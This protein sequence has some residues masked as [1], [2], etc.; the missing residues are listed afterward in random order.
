VPLVVLFSGS[1]FLTEI[2]LRNPETFERLV[3][4][5]RMARPKSVEQ[6]FNEAQAALEGVRGYPEQ[7][8]GL[9][10]FQSWEMLR[11][12]ACD[13][14]DLYDLPAVT[15]QLSNLADAM[16]RACLKLAAAQAGGKIDGL[17]VLG[18]GKLGGREL[19]YSSD[20]D[21]IFLSTAD[22]ELAQQV[23]MKLIDALARAT[24]EG[25]LYRVDMRLRPW[26]S[27]GPLVSTPAG[28]IQYLKT[29][30]LPWEKQALLKARV[31]A[32]DARLGRGFLEQAQPY[33]FGVSFEELRA[34]GFS[35]K[36]RTEAQLRLNG[37][38][39]GEVK[40]GEGSIRDVE[41]T[42]QFLQLAYG[43]AR[44]EI[45]SANTL[46]AL[47]RLAAAEMIS[48]D[49]MRILTEGDVFLR[50]GEHYLQMMDCRQT[51]SLP[52]DAPALAGLARRLGF[53]GR[54]PGEQFVER[55][56]QHGAAIR[57]VFLHYVGGFEMTILPDAN[58]TFDAARQDPMQVHRHIDRMTPSYAEI[59]SKEEIARH[60]ALAG[61][62]NDENSVEV[63]A[64]PGDNNTWR[65]TVVAYDFPGELSVLT[66]LLFVYGL[67]IVA[68]EAFTYEP[69]A[70]TGER[71]SAHD[72]RRKIVDV[73]DLQAVEGVVIS[74]ETWVHYANDLAGYQRMVRASKRREMQG[75]LTRRVAVVIE[76]RYGRQLCIP[77]VST[78]ITR[79]ATRIPC[80]ASMRRIRPGSCTSSPTRW[81]SAGSI[82]SRW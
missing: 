3:A 42:A 44:P 9:R 76:G 50:T 51:H 35:L 47:V 54:Q 57:A 2:M 78:S 40:L 77:S 26:G 12:G 60:A 71:S 4:Y 10:R 7:L 80:C 8:D 75:D 82:L 69:F 27:V 58:P 24:S 11:I 21:L 72:T 65:L 29:S 33:I 38:S 28:F 19:N 31:I 1:Q 25:F 64:A 15:R 59:F 16:I 37:R 32:G 20:I 36:Q 13:L 14:L 46:E 18:M 34:S 68:G 62:L 74:A 22:P 70:G 67:N 41:F 45:L 81:R 49:E 63:E 66:G 52:P 39:W 48:L 5:R 55:Y 23:G 61:L 56:E 53:G 30:A 79:P 73:F 17:T 43:T 6:L